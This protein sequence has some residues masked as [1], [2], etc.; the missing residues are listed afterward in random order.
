VTDSDLEV[1]REMAGLQK[2]R[3]SAS[4]AT[5]AGISKLQA[6]LPKLQVTR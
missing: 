6:A 4:K 2:L 1:I 5:A 3:L